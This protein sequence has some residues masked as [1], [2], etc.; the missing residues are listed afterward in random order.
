M[1][2]QISDWSILWLV[3]GW[4]EGKGYKHPHGS[5]IC[6][7]GERL[8]DIGEVLLVNKEFPVIFQGVILKEGESYS[9]IDEN[10]IE[11]KDLQN[12][13][14]DN[15]TALIIVDMQNDFCK[16]NGSLAVEGSLEIIPLIN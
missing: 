13:M 3:N 5:T 8:N 10:S 11:Y 16:P 7:N 2:K 14:I 6:D 12:K 1:Q 4:T 9:T 15:K